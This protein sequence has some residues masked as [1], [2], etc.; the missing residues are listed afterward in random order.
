[1]R[2]LHLVDRLSPRGGADHHLRDLLLEQR[3]RHRLHVA[4]GRVEPGGRLPAGVHGHRVKGLAHPVDGGRGLYV[5]EQL[6]PGFDIVHLHN[7]MN[8]SAI[9]MAVATG[10]AVATIQDHRVFCPGPGRT[11]PSGAACDRPMSEAA[12][13]ACL[14]DDDY[15]RRT[16]AV[17]RARR[18]ALQGARLIALSR[19][20]ADALDQA[21]LPGAAVIPPWVEVAAPRAAPGRGFVLGG[22][23]VAHKDPLLSWRAWR[24]AGVDHPLVVAGAG[25]LEPA[26]EGAD[27]RGWLQRPRLREA[28][29]GARALLFCPRW[30][31]P[32]GILGVEALAE[33]TPVIAARVGGV[34]DW[35]DAGVIEVPPGDEAAL[36]EAIR[37]LADDP[38]RALAL[39]EAGRR[40]VAERFSKAPLLARIEAV[41]G[42]ARLTAR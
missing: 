13:A 29:R 4:F 25:P 42:A 30:Q 19:Y 6:L 12:C 16:L 5:L 9:A 26:L 18:D 32:F 37:A 8:P 24:R 31:E 15:R 35:A 41:Y 10:R 34:G 40:L 3:R 11:L 39:G 21:G 7:I 27:R 36:A 38:A 2:V 17:T 33:G 28:L 1:M 14:P 23:L 22:R 20:M